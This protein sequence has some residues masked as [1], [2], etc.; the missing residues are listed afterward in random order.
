MV[1]LT[2]KMYKAKARGN[3]RVTSKKS[4]KNMRGGMLSVGFGPNS[5]FVKILQKL[6]LVKKNNPVQEVYYT[7][8][9]P[10]PRVLYGPGG[11]VVEPST[12]INI[13]AEPNPVKRL[14]AEPTT[15]EGLYQ[16]LNNFTSTRQNSVKSVKS[17]KPVEPN[18]YVELL[19]GPGTVSH[20]KTY[21][22]PFQNSI[23]GRKPIT[24]S[25]VSKAFQGRNR[26]FIREPAPNIARIVPEMI[27]TITGKLYVAPMG[28]P[29]PRRPDRGSNKPPGKLPT[30]NTSP[31][32]PQVKHK[33][34]KAGN[35]GNQQVKSFRKDKSFRALVQ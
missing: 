26:L 8:I 20:P 1:V 5:R 32:G 11:K 3:S 30:T 4:K 21:M 10:N 2:K 23:P 22:D 18:K 31:F 19:P 9:K 27:N 13:Y 24:G 35:A 12:D 15:D 34:G 6:G 25:N 29:P 17:V 16:N 7:E 33:Q 28:I 14:Y